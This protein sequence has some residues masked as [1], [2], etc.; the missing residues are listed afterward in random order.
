MREE[1][2][3]AKLEKGWVGGKW[4]LRKLSELEACN[5]AVG[6]PGRSERS[7]GGKE[8]VHESVF[9]SSVKEKERLLNTFSLA[10]R[11]K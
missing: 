5:E 2:E 9:V 3:N 4:I 10:G 1:K 7:L 6:I 8:D 11:L